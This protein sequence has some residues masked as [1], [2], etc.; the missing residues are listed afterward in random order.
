MQAEKELSEA[1]IK[2]DI[3]ITIGVFDGVHIGH[4]YLLSRLK[5]T[6]NAHRA[7]S[8]VIT[9]RRHPV[10][11]LNPTIALPYLT[12]LDEKVSLLKAEGINAVVA[13]TFD[14]ELAALGAPDF[15][16]LLR[17]YLK[18][19]GLVI[20]P[21]FALGRNREGNV[22]TLIKL[23]KQ[24][25]FS[26]TVVPPLKLDGEIISSTAIRQALAV[27]DMTKVVKLTGR[28]YSLKGCI[29]KGTGIGR[30]LGYPTANLK[31]EPGWAIPSDGVYA[32]FTHVNGN[33][34]RSMTSIGLRPTF[35]GKERTVETYLIDYQ[36][37]L[38]GREVWIDIVERLRDEIK[39]DNVEELKAQITRD[40][41]K[42]K[43]VLDSKNHGK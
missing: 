31:I 27:G 22:D 17:R 14:K 33:I 37:D 30:Q 12:S 35:G 39:F 8:G 10:E 3:V 19:C 2:Y 6:A 18:L 13:L 36:G 16:D 9:F 34:H 20:G 1:N 23:G 41:N 11:L 21:D 42:G 25:G 15:I 32:T 5:D 29:I 26:V 40:I 43:A 4:K 38:Y 24:R 7:A 28:P